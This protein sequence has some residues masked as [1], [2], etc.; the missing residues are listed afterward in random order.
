MVFSQSREEFPSAL[1]WSLSFTI[2]LTL[3]FAAL[4]HSVDTG[5]FS[6]SDSCVVFSV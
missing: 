3:N 1:I 5:V 6:D 2:L 4:Q